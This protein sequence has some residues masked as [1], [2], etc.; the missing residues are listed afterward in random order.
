MGAA[1]LGLAVAVAYCAALPAAWAPPPP[2]PCAQVRSAADCGARCRPLSADQLK[3]RRHEATA[4]HACGGDAGAWQHWDWS[5]ITSVAQFCSTHAGG[6]PGNFFALMCAA[7]EHG[8]RVLSW[9]DGPSAIDACYN[10][11]TGVGVDVTNESAVRA[12]ATAAVNQTQAWGYDGM[13]FD[14]EG[15]M[16]GC[17]NGSALAQTLAVTADAMHAADPASLVVFSSP[18]DPNATFPSPPGNMRGAADWSLI[19]SKF[20]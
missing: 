6:Y 4:Y 15:G 18:A 16:A 1:G 14:I 11:T 7:H 17:G 12:F 2:P 8:V 3:P 5:R 9:Q 19:G 10:A 20:E 13:I